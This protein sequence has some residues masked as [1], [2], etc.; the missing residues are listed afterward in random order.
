MDGFGKGNLGAHW[1]GR[2]RLLGP[3]GLPFRILDH[4]SRMAL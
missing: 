3:S 4:V 1:I 2:R